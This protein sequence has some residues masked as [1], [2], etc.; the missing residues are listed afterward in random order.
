MTFVFL[1]KVGVYFKRWYENKIFNKL[2]KSFSVSEHILGFRVAVQ[3]VVT[4]A[5]FKNARNVHF[6]RVTIIVIIILYKWVYG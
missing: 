6:C 1:A 3:Q 2:T 4:H 5:R